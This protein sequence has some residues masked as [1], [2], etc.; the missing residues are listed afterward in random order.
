MTLA[1]FSRLCETIE[2]QSPTQ[3]KAA[4]AAGLSSFDRPEVVIAILSLDLPENNIGEKRA[5]KWIANSMALFDSEVQSAVDMWGDIGEG[6]N[7]LD[8]GNET[9]SNISLDTFYNLLIMDCSSM[10][11]NSFNVMSEHLNEMSA[12]EKKWFVRYWL[13]KPRNGI[14]ESTVIKAMQIRHP[15]EDIKKLSH[16]SSLF[17]IEQHLTEGKTIKQG[18][19]FGTF[20]KPMLAKPYVVKKKPEKVLIDI[21]YDGNRYQIHKRRSDVIV[22]NRRGKIV[23]N[24][25]S[26]VVDWLLKLDFNFV[27]DTEIYPINTDGSPA[28]HK[29][30]AK[31]VHKKDK[32]EAIR[33]C[34]VK[35][36]IFD[37]LALN[38]VSYLDDPLFARVETL[39]ETFPEMHLAYVFDKE[40]TL[41]TAY[42][43]AINRGFEGIMIKDA[44]LTYQPGKR[45]IGWLKYKPPRFELDVVITSGQYGKGKRTGMFGS[46]GISVKDGTDYINVGSCGTGF[47][48]DDLSL[49]TNDLRKIIDGYEGDNYLFLPRVVIQVTCD[50]I[51]NDADGNIGLRF[52]RCMRLRPDKFPADIDTLERLKE[53]M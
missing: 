53:L 16:F 33:E 13:R 48:E 22:F 5:I 38:G 6:I 20:V 21:K 2:F 1:R 32:A 34:P 30:M 36:A 51:T 46:F 25:F 28:E 40:D 49:L 29:L 14:N 11:G 39:K 8:V 10:Q 24:Q 45:S 50:L 7:E 31:R 9:D 41:E 19:S 47:S 18:L 12:R 42:N 37:L 3:T 26:D 35:L 27:I 44:N 23:T 52:P 4:I 43:I 17:K 15:S